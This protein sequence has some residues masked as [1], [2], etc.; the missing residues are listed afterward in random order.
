MA[1]VVFSGSLLAWPVADLCLGPQLI[2]L[3]MRARPEQ[4]ADLLDS[5]VT[6]SVSRETSS[7]Q[8]ASIVAVSGIYAADR[9]GILGT[10]AHSMGVW[11]I[12][13][14]DIVVGYEPE[15]TCAI[16][17]SLILQHLR[18]ALRAAHADLPVGA[19]RPLVVLDNLGES[20]CHKD[21]PQMRSMLMHF[22]AWCTAT[23]YDDGLADIVIC[24][25]PDDSLWKRSFT[26]GRAQTFYKS[27]TFKDWLRMRWSL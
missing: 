9:L 11:W 1:L 6:T 18:R 21:D 4:T 14:F 3:G 22:V 26:A 20:T 13:L 16:N 10:L 12:T 7:A 19:S 24:D 8:H 17:F 5:S 27:H 2:L 23:C 15:K 25:E